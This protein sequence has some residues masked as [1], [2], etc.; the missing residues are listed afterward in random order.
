MRLFVAIE[1]SEEV[2]SAVAA[3]AHELTA[4]APEARWTKAEKMHL[5]LA[6]LGE[7]PEA[8]VG[9]LSKAIS[10]AASRHPALALRARGGGAFGAPG[11]SRV[12]WAGIEGDVGGL[13]KLQSEVAAAL[14]PYG[15]VNEHSAFTG[16]LTLARAKKP[17]G[18]AKLAECAE[19]LSGVELGSWPVTEVLLMLS[20]GGG[21]QILA[22]APLR[23]PSP[24]GR[25]T[26]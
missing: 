8:K 10:E 15:Y 16:H 9:E 13:A 24:I 1:L 5:T 18:D 7:Q 19:R 25:G 26:G 17:R 23:V 6:F 14:A 21:Y 20:R 3:L 4:I 22:R 2:R 11:H 12:L